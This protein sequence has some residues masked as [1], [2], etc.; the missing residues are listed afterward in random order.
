MIFTTRMVPGK[1]RGCGFDLLSLMSR[2]CNLWY[3]HPNRQYYSG[4][5]SA[6]RAWLNFQRLLTR[7]ER[8]DDCVC[9]SERSVHNFEDRLAE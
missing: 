4:T 2:M 7:R 8:V 3:K 9:L 6:I 5:D 1:K